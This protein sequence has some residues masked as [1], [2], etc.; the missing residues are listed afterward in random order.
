MKD[1]YGGALEYFWGLWQPDLCWFRRDRPSS[2][3]LIGGGAKL[4][5]GI[6]FFSPWLI[7]TGI[8]Y[9]G[10]CAARGGFLKYTADLP[11]E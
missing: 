11:Y 6:V 9:L 4:V 7:V 5:L 3:R 1:F 8:Y 2:M 10:F